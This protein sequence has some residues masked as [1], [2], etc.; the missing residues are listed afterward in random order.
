M[1]MG[2]IT[3]WLPK[4]FLIIIC[5]FYFFWGNFWILVLFDSKFHVFNLVGGKSSALVKGDEI[6]SFDLTN[7]QEGKNVNSVYGSWGKNLFVFLDP[8]D[9]ISC[10]EI[11]YL[12]KIVGSE[13]EKK[14][15]LFVIPVPDSL[16]TSNLSQEK[17]KTWLWHLN[18]ELSWKHQLLPTFWL[19][20]NGVL[21]DLQDGFLSY[22]E[23]K[24]LIEN[25]VHPYGTSG[26]LVQYTPDNWSQIIPPDSVYNITWSLNE[27]QWL[28]SKT[29]SQGS[30]PKVRVS[31]TW[32]PM[33]SSL[34]YEVKIFDRVCD[35]E[36]LPVEAFNLA[37]V[38]I[39]PLDAQI[40]SSEIFE[41]IP[42]SNLNQML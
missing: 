15:K 1:K 31:L 18:A 33:D 23:L 20:E 9:S 10:R 30:L 36:G 29:I 11:S 25:F 21:V 5:V 34:N 17:S 26:Q 41:A 24:E 14:L 27:I 35:C 8:S 39:N 32:N 38:K 16:S 37:V 6:P 4:W 22:E 13:T 12:E 2:K 7:N 19:V 40:L 28:F 3:K 42:E